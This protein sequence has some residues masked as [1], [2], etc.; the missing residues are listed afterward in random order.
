[1]FLESSRYYKLRQEDTTTK[2]GR[3]VKAVSLR[4][5][6][7]TAGVPVLI[8]ANDALDIM[9]E[10]QYGDATRFWHIAD[11]NTELEAGRL[12]DAGRTI[13]VPES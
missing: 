10:R 1:M 11:A 7:N 12:I 4:R 3:T 2:D 8:K 5:L 9:A 6:P 13:T